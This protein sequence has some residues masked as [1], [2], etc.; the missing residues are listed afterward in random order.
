MITGKRYFSALYLFLLFAPAFTSGP[1]S[2]PSS[3]DF[4]SLPV[5]PISGNLT[6]MPSPQPTDK[7]LTLNE[8]TARQLEAWIT[9]YG[10]VKEYVNQVET[11]SKQVADSW[12]KVKASSTNYE[13]AM[14]LQI[15]VRDDEIQRLKG[16][17]VKFTAAGFA[18]GLLVGFIIGILQ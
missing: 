12:E 13:K 14:F 11:W 18:S 8:R 9:Y 1:E 3:P 7:P 2:L 16:D 6:T 4:S 5:F 10:M 15:E 17:V